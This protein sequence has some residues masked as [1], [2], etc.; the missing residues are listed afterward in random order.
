MDIHE[1]EH[2]WSSTQCQGKRTRWAEVTHLG[3]RV[4]TDTKERGKQI[5]GKH[6]A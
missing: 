4:D 1:L 2:C 6:R 3:S 5:E